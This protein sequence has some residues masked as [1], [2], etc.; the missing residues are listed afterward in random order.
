VTVSVANDRQNDLPLPRQTQIL[1]FLHKKPSTGTDGEE[2][3]PINE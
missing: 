2:R 1:N 3:L